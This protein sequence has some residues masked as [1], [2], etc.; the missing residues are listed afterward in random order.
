[1]ILLTT[2]INSLPWTRDVYRGLNARYT[3][4]EINAYGTFIITTIVYWALGLIFMAFDM[5]FLHAYVKKYKV[6]P[7]QIS[8]AEYRDVCLIV[9]RNQ[10]FV[11]LPLAMLGPL[12]S[13]LDTSGET[14]PGL[15]TTTWT[16]FF[17]LLCEEVGFFVVHRACHS[18]L[19]YVRVHK[20]HHQ[21]TAP[22]ALASTYC[23]IA[24]HVFVGA[25]VGISSPSPTSSPS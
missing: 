11:A 25:Q 18:K 24:E 16:Y 23:T 8:W 12:L 5:T 17:C 6:Q 21:F 14:L 4:F 13:T 2:Y 1:M 22:V 7:K 9:L 15:W 20:L 19:L 10:V 3:P